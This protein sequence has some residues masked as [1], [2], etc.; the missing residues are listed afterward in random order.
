[1]PMSPR[2]LLLNGK[3]HAARTIVKRIYLHPE[4]I[5]PSRR[6]PYSVWSIIITV[7]VVWWNMA[8]YTI[9]TGHRHRDPRHL[10]VG[11]ARARSDAR[12]DATPGTRCAI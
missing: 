6:R 12:R 2:W 1:M 5:G 9:A 3:Y 10:G 7:R 8:G 4:V 11:G